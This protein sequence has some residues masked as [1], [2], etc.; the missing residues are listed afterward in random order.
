MNPK[1]K[2]VQAI[3]CDMLRL[4]CETHLHQTT[5]HPNSYFGVEYYSVFMEQIT[6]SDVKEMMKHQA[7]VT[8]EGEQGYFFVECNEESKS[9]NT[10]ICLTT[11]GFVDVIFPVLTIMDVQARE[12]GT[13]LIT[14]L[15]DMIDKRNNVYRFLMYGNAMAGL[16][17]FLKAMGYLEEEY[18]ANLADDQEPEQA[19]QS[20]MMMARSVWMVQFVESRKL[21]SNLASEAE[22]VEQHDELSKLIDLLRLANNVNIHAMP[23]LT[24]L[25]HAAKEVSDIRADTVEQLVEIFNEVNKIALPTIFEMKADANTQTAGCILED[26]MNTMNTLMFCSTLSEK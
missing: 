11:N 14:A 22:A 16:I 7:T 8:D 3:I 23:Y 15:R 25:S 24:R 6:N 19:F 13:N 1:Y 9:L 21:A 26:F 20:A 2:N 4:E 10:L 5:F 17:A 18:E 12:A